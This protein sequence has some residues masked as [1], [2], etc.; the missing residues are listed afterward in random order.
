MISGGK[1]GDRK[2]R[3]AI[4]LSAGVGFDSQG[5]HNENV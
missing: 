1:L 2:I 4:W 3:I 5:T